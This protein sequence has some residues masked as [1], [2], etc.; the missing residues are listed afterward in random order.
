MNLMKV[1]F[2]PKKKAKTMATRKVI[3]KVAKKSDHVN[4]NGLQAASEDNTSAF[5]ND[6]ANDS[7]VTVSPEVSFFLF[8]ISSFAFK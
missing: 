4:Q 1:K 8:F 7:G 3:K 6:F 5:A 2:L